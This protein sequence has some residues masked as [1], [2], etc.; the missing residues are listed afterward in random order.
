MYKGFYELNTIPFSLAPDP[1]FLFRTESIVE[2]MAN[3][4]YGIENGKGLVVV[5]GEAGTGKTTLLRSMLQTL[6]RSITA[7]YIFNPLLSTE[8]FFGVLSSELRL[9]SQPPSKSEALRNLGAMLV[10]RQATGQRTVL[11]VD[12]AHMLQPH[13]LEEIRLLSNF[14]T[15]REKLIQIVLCGQPDLRD[16]LS[17]PAWRHLKQRVSLR[18]NVRALTSSETPHYISWRL[19]VSGAKQLSLFEPEA[20]ALVHRYSAG[21]PRVINNICDNALLTGFSRSIPQIT[22]AV[23]RDVVEVL[24]LVAARPETGMT[25]LGNTFSVAPAED[26]SNRKADN[27]KVSPIIKPEEASANNVRLLRPEAP[28][29]SKAVAVNGSRIAPR[30]YGAAPPTKN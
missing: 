28:E 14:E 5:T 19:R 10:A 12:E 16:L 9:G 22:A 27:G 26:Q 11:V 17:Q 2:A 8:D 7:A 25:G 1:R 3:V 6:D 29:A 20:L 21:I 15:N 4:Q 23:V 18:C 30:K 13:L 24:D